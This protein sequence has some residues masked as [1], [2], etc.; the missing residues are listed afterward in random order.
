M[1]IFFNQK[2]INEEMLLKYTHT[3]TYTV[4]VPFLCTQNGLRE[5]FKMKWPPGL[6]KQEMDQP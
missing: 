3:H 2:C 5:A 6:F 1:S 4:L